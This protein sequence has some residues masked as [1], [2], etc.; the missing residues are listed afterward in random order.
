MQHIILAFFD[1]LCN[2]QQPS[3]PKALGRKEDLQGD[4]GSNMIF[5]DN[6]IARL[7]LIAISSSTLFYD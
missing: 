2:F 5:E 7:K 4:L 1:K 6:A 3:S